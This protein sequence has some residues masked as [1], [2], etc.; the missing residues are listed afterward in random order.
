MNS[1]NLKDI[2]VVSGGFLSDGADVASYIHDMELKQKAKNKID[3]IGG[4]DLPPPFDPRF[5]V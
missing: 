3:P 5:V 2:E 1:L 4:I